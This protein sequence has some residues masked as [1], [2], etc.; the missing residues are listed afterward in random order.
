MR[1]CVVMGEGVKDPFRVGQDCISFC[2]IGQDGSNMT[3]DQAVDECTEAILNNTVTNYCKPIL[4][5]NLTQQIENCAE[6]YLVR[7]LPTP[8]YFYH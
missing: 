4:T 5:T 2:C 1:H 3:K 7:A 8:S 6:D